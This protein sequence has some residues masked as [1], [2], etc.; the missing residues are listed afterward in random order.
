MR[1]RNIAYRRAVF[2]QV[3]YGCF[4]RGAHFAVE[5]LPKIIA[6]AAQAKF[7]ERLAKSGAEIFHAMCGRRGVQGIPSRDQAKQDCGVGNAVRE[8][9][10]VIEAWRESNRAEHA[11]ATER[12]LQPYDSA[13][14]RRNSNRATSVRA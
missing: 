3:A 14:R 11:H 10:D 6:S 12:R 13:H 7:A 2:F 1:Q 9:A 8:R 5:L 4:R